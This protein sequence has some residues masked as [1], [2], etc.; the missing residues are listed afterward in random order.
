MTVA[1]LLITN[2]AYAKQQ[3]EINSKIVKGQDAER[4][5]FPYYV[6]LDIQSTLGKSVCGGSLI[7]D[8]WIVTAA[9]CLDKVTSIQVNLGSLRAKNTKETGRKIIK[10]TK[11]DLHIY[12]KNPQSK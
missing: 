6:F 3:L 5:Q 9:H 10:V 4:G 2:N 11:K 1:A 7:S 12:P 8:Q